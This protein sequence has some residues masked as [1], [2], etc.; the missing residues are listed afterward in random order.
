MGPCLLPPIVSLSPLASSCTLAPSSPLCLCQPDALNIALLINT[1]TEREGK[2]QPESE[3]KAPVTVIKM[4]EV[5]GRDGDW[6]ERVGGEK[7]GGEDTL[8]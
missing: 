7:E 8:M 4:S 1:E 6:V 3:R 5:Q 2:R